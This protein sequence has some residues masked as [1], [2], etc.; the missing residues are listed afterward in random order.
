MANGVEFRVP[1]FAPSP[2]PRL[3]V[4]FDASV[5]GLGVYGEFPVCAV[6]PFADQR[7]GAG[8]LHL[9]AEGALAHTYIRTNHN[10]WGLGY[11]I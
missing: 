9:S 6:D 1:L 8:D 5:Y 10:I 3:L 4:P 2:C 7:P 11:S